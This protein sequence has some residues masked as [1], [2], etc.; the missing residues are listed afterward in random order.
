MNLDPNPV[1]G[2]L[3]RLISAFW[4]GTVQHQ[5]HLAVIKALGLS[6]LATQ[7]QAHIAD[8]P[9]TLQQLTDRL[10]DLDGRPS[11]TLAVPQLGSTLQ[12]V[13]HLDLATQLEAR[14]VLNAA[15][16][17][18]AAAHDAVTRR[19]IED[20]LADEEAHLYWL[21]SELSLLE[22]MGEQAYIAGRS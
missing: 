15:A 10:L 11:F 7:M 12:E 3:N 8:E 13:L 22:R 16:E 1:H 14:P 21:K 19:L 6:S 18:V 9:A 17:A 20:I 4:Q 2:V 5:T